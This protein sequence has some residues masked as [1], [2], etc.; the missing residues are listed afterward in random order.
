M[1]EF[2]AVVSHVGY[3]TNTYNFEGYIRLNAPLWAASLSVM[4][5][6]SN[7]RIKNYLQ[8]AGQERT[9]RHHPDSDMTTTD[10]HGNVMKPCASK[11]R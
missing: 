11:H 9:H 7:T 1:V 3:R 2:V 10:M 6:F 5:S 8:P 4:T